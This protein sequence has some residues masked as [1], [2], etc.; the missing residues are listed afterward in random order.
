MIAKF[1]LFDMLN[2]VTPVKRIAPAL[3]LVL[4][5]PFVAP[6]P[7]LG[8]GAAAIV[9]SLLA[10]NPFATDERAGLD[11]LYA[12][13]PMTRRS[14][15]LGR[16]ISLVVLYLIVASLGT[17]AAIVVHIKDG[18]VVDFR[19]LQL[20]N[21]VALLIFIGGLAVQLPFFFSVG[22]TRARFMTFIPAA[23]LVGGAALASQLGLIH[24]ADLI[25]V[26]SHNVN[27]LLL[28]ALIIGAAALAV[29]VVIS[30]TQYSRR[31]L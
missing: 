24:G 5:A 13:L 22:F 3:F 25:R 8:I 6:W 29:S 12:T 4:V 27:S 2:F 23:L 17:V 18:Q 31:A 19:L 9:M 7:A 20:V 30:A 11:T 15:V 1:V 26:V 21:V 28:P 14:V 10:S 16:Y